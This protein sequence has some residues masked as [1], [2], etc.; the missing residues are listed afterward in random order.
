MPPTGP[1]T[2][3][4]QS[5]LYIICNLEKFSLDELRKLSSN[6]RY[7]LL[8]NLP[9]VDASRL[10]DAG[11]CEGVNGKLLW[12]ELVYTRITDRN[13][14]EIERNLLYE[15]NL[16]NTRRGFYFALML[17]ILF[18]H[19]NPKNRGYRSHYEFVLYLLFGVRGCLDISDWS[20]YNFTYFVPTVKDR[21]LVFNRHLKHLTTPRSD[22]AFL[23]LFLELFKYR[24][25]FFFVVSDLFGESDV[26]KKHEI[27][28]LTPLLSQVELVAFCSNATGRFGSSPTGKDFPYDVPVLILKAILAND[29]PAVKRIQFRDFNGPTLDQSL[30]A[31]APLF[32]AA[33]HSLSSKAS[34]HI[35]YRS[36]EQLL[37]DVDS[38]KDPCSDE[39]FQ[40]IATIINAQAKLTSLSVSNVAQGAGKYSDRFHKFVGSINAFVKKEQATQITMKQMNFQTKSIQ[41]IIDSYLS[42]PSK[43]SSCLRFESCT[44]TGSPSFESTRKIPMHESNLEFKDLEFHCCKLPRNFFA[45][46]FSI[47]RLWLHKLSVSQC[48]LEDRYELA[49]NRPEDLL[50]LAAACDDLRVTILEL[51]AVVLYHRRHSAEHFETLLSNSSLKHLSLHNCRIGPHGVITDLTAG[52]QKQCSLGTLQVLSLQCNVLGDVPT[53]EFQSL[54]NTLFSHANLANFEINIGHNEFKEEH[55]GI[56]YKAWQENSRGQPVKHFTCLDRNFPKGTDHV[57]DVGKCIESIASKCYFWRR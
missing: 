22:I 36:L 55:Y 9:V 7:D 52:L 13:C 14:Q 17:H 32:Y 11:L 18:D 1:L 6:V 42:C 3:R 47:S 46:V 20:E 30:K 4:Q 43:Q 41:Q 40:K 45:W 25:S 34:K 33:Y 54:F 10:Q 37:F 2:L 27:S 48:T 19:I 53:E 38:T 8:Y 57:T 50:A 16:C 12:D 39:V 44:F 29:P 56:I 26:Y 15:S 49:F 21:P 28:L 24:P 35:P 31:A 51:T 5:L 23:K